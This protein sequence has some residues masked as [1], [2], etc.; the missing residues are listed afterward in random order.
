MNTI[1]ECLDESCMYRT[2]E[3]SCMNESISLNQEHRCM[4]FIPIIEPEKQEAEK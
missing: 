3:G 2:P 1:Y 4:N